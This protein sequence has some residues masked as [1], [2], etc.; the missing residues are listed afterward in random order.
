MGS[1]KQHQ[2]PDSLGFK[3]ASFFD[4]ARQEF[5][6]NLQSVKAV[7]FECGNEFDTVMVGGVAVGASDD[8]GHTFCTDGCATAFTVRRNNERK[9]ARIAQVKES[10]DQ[11]L[12]HAGVPESLVHARFFNF[13]YQNNLT[14][15]EKVVLIA[16]KNSGVGKSHL[17]VAILANSM[18]TD[19]LGGYF[20]TPRMFSH[21]KGHVQETVAELSNCP[22]L[23]IDDLGSEKPTEAVKSSLYDIINNR[24]SNYRKTIVTTNLSPEEVVGIYGQ[25]IYSRIS[26]GSIVTVDG[27]DMRRG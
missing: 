11:M 19:G 27:E 24:T 4:K 6:L 20:V 26:C 17:A 3:S 9:M 13:K 22:I 10:I 1:F 15:D 2:D 16:G 12:R 5:R 18:L 7:C 23:I 8:T 25:R 21:Y 14:G